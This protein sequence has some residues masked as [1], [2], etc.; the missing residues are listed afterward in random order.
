[1]ELHGQEEGRVARVEREVDKLS[2]FGVGVGDG[3][4]SLFFFFILALLVALPPDL[5]R[6]PDA[7]SREHEKQLVDASRVAVARRHVP[8]EE[9]LDTGGEPDVGVRKRVKGDGEAVCLVLEAEGREGRE[10]AGERAAAAEGGG[11]RAL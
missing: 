5:L 2:A 1:M 8:R 6:H 11:S 4:A 7:A 9:D 10:A 3:G